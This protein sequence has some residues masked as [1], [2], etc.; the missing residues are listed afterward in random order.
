LLNSELC[1]KLDKLKKPSA[2][3]MRDALVEK[4]NIVIDLR[5]DMEITVVEPPNPTDKGKKRPALLSFG[6][7]VN[8]GTNVQKLTAACRELGS[9]LMDREDNEQS[10]VLPA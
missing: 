10:L 6:I 9:F 7:D 5:E 2:R 8:N 4:H 1:G 3:F